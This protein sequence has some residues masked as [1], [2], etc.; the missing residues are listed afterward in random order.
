MQ[1]LKPDLTSVGYKRNPFPVWGELLQSGPC[2]KVKLPFIGKVWATTTFEATSQLLRDEDRFVRNPK[3]AGR[4]YML[5]FQWLLPHRINRLTNNMLGH[6][7]AQHRRLRKLV[8]HAFLQQSIDEM[9]PRIEE[10]CDHFLNQSASL[11]AQHGSVDLIA[12]FSRPFPLAVISELL[13]LPEEDRPRFLK[14]GEG[15]SKIRSIFDFGRLLLGL[16]GL[17]K[18]F[19]EQ[20]EACRKQPRPGLLSALVQVELEGDKLS[21]EE[22]MSTAFLLLFAGHE[23]TIH[24]ITCAVYSFLTHPDEMQKLVNNRSLVAPA[25]EEVLRYFSPIEFTKPRYVAEDTSFFGQDLKRGEYI[26]GLIGTANHDP[27]K[28]VQ[29]EL[30]D[31]S[32][33][34]NPHLSFGTGVHI[35]L[36]L[37]L[38][39]AETQIALER[40]FTRFPNLQCQTPLENLI[41]IGRP[42]VRALHSLPLVLTTDLGEVS[43][44]ASRI[45]PWSVG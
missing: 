45:T 42:G 13:G 17:E 16:R 6:D 1:T 20:F 28:Y 30:F 12:N 22:L 10:I 32:R 3:N 38:A 25:V 19:E 35:C 11:A 34:P 29:P 9:Q 4:K 27:A 5:P 23:T 33:T 26:V 40:I 2:L 24:L 36:G 44:R 41:W 31:I 39:R 7:H 15:F 8:E 37:K 14:W 18:Y 21:Y 43:D